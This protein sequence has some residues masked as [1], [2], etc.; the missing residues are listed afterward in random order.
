[1]DPDILNILTNRTL[2]LG[3]GVSFRCRVVGNPRPR[4]KWKRNGV[5]IIQ[6]GRIKIRFFSWGSRLRI[7]NI[8]QSDEGVYRCLAKSPIG[9]KVSSPA[10]VRIRVNDAVSSGLDRCSAF[11]KR[12][13]KK[14]NENILCAQGIMGSDARHFNT[15]LSSN[16]Y[17]F[18]L[19]D[20]QH[21]V[22]KS[23]TSSYVLCPKKRLQSSLISKLPRDVTKLLTNAQNK[24]LK[25]QASII[26][27]NTNTAYCIPMNITLKNLV[28]N[29]SHYHK[30]LPF[31]NLQYQ[32]SNIE[33]PGIEVT[34]DDFSSIETILVPLGSAVSYRTH[35]KFQLENVTFFYR[36]QSSEG[37][38]L[39]KGKYRLCE[40]VFDV[41]VVALNNGVIKITGNSSSPLDVNTIERVFGLTIPSVMIQDAIRRSELLLMR[42][43]SP[44]LEAYVDGDITVKFSGQSYFS[45]DGHPTFLELYGGK[46]SHSNVLVTSLST[47]GL[48]FNHALRIFTGIDLPS[49]DWM[50]HSTND[51]QIG[52]L[53]ST[54]ELQ[55][56]PNSLYH[57]KGEP[58]SSNLAGSIPEGLTI[59]TQTRVPHVCNGS[60][61][62]ELMKVMFGKD[63]LFTAKINSN[64]NKVT[65]DIAVK[66]AYNDALLNYQAITVSL[67]VVKGNMT[68]L[69]VL[70][71]LTFKANGHIHLSNMKEEKLFFNGQLDYD[72]M[73]SKLHGVFQLNQD[74]V[75]AFGVKY[76]TL[77]NLRA[78]FSIPTDA[79]NS[80]TQ[81]ILNTRGDVYFGA[82]CSQPHSVSKKNSCIT[83]QGFL[84]LSED[85]R[86]HYFYGKLGPV[87]IKQLLEAYDFK[88]QLPVAIASIGFPRGL[89]ISV[90]KT[91][92]DERM[93]GGPLVQPGLVMSGRLRI[94]GIESDATV[95]LSPREFLI[96]ADV[97][98]ESLEQLNDVDPLERIKRNQ[99]ST[100]KLYMKARINP[101]AFLKIKI[102]GYSRIFG[103]FDEVHILV[104]GEMTQ[105]KMV[106]E[107]HKSIYAHV[108]LTSNYS[109]HINNTRLRAKIIFKNELSK[110]TRLASKHVVAM[111]A[112]EMS[113]IKTAEKEVKQLS[114]DCSKSAQKSCAECMDQSNCF[115]ALLSCYKGMLR[116]RGATTLQSICHRIA[117]DSRLATNNTCHK[118]IAVIGAYS[119]NSCFAYHEAANT[120]QKVQRSLRWVRQARVLVSGS[121]FNL[122]GISFEA[123]VLPINLRDTVVDTTF[124][125]TIF[126]QRNVLKGLK[127]RFDSFSRLASEI[128][129]KAFVWYNRRR[130]F[131][132]N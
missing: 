46:L 8:Q 18:I 91:M 109:K 20:D 34:M 1:R 30:S 119:N 75:N 124:D 69:D 84:G 52:V 118:F 16:Y 42:L 73:M 70:P 41:V 112:T 111:L 39:A 26:K 96:D 53:L 15:R 129:K 4:I 6:S 50:R 55:A 99:Q 3:H 64:Q 131:Y 38:F 11:L 76:M 21:S 27:R 35:A 33:I 101:T 62:C 103:I 24:V 127:L 17:C 13:E 90:A 105:I 44:T 40:S 121:L 22:M 48:A 49:F 106:A 12:I 67:N 113:K 120:L 68:L 51:S 107:I 9:H 63:S 14:A 93:K 47:K 74:W 89:K 66:N 117:A 94:L 95:S 78:S 82:G 54:T 29:W 128:A 23:L 25:G 28:W 2:S 80:Q 98:S 5:T 58:L 104:S 116:H 19:L 87:T 110:L 79:S 122:H 83:G 92:H 32:P 114:K 36:Y 31:P 7:R 56:R 45:F 125:V 97:T 60:R 132:G 43:M 71:F 65:F 108:Y 88:V 126:G 61:F 59:I 86:K 72:G 57:I 130:R 77:K 10:Y 37:A 85:V 123:E 102:S 115:S 81:H 100:A